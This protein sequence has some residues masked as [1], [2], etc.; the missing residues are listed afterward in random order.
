MESLDAYRSFLERYN[1][2]VS[3]S[4][5]VASGE[6]SAAPTSADA[7]A[8]TSGVISIDEEAIERL[9]DKIIGNSIDSA[10]AALAEIA[11]RA[12]PIATPLAFH[13]AAQEVNFRALVHALSIGS[14]HEDMAHL[15]H[16]SSLADVVLF[17]VIGA[18][19]ANSA[20]DAKFLRNM[21]SSDASSLFS[22]PRHQQ[23]PSEHSWITIEKPGG[24]LPYADLLSD[25]MSYYGRE[26]QRDG[27]RDWQQ[28]LSKLTSGAGSMAHACIM[29]ASRLDR[30]DDRY[31]DLGT[32]GAAPSCMPVELCF[33]KNLRRLLHDLHCIA[34]IAM[35]DAEAPQATDATKARA[36]A[37]A[38]F[39]L[40]KRGG[41]RT[42]IAAPSASTVQNLER[43]Q[44]LRIRSDKP[45]AEATAADATTEAQL[46]EVVRDA[47]YEAA[48]RCAAIVACHH[49]SDMLIERLVRL[50]LHSS[51]ED[52]AINPIRVSILLDSYPMNESQAVTNHFVPK[53][54]GNKW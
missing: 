27:S 53:V 52:A 11:P 49:I 44:V 12:N 38:P 13:D 14:Q 48:V 15:A 29:I 32:S 17:G 42:A 37:L 28:M 23:V 35:R 54:T 19:I 3:S 41:L 34:D 36:A 31:L 16:Q 33:F 5:A 50:G 6:S 1:R 40:S 22:L 24:M 39:R 30:F 4:A 20:L 10:S 18:H 43:F 26:M 2:D 46:P 25:T 8:T 9:V 51:A 7:P 47:A 45:A 21:T